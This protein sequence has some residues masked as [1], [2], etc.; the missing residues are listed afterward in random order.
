MLAHAVNKGK[1]LDTIRQHE[2]TQPPERAKA[3]EALRP[4]QLLHPIPHVQ[5]GVRITWTR[6]NGASYTGVV[7]RIHVD[8]TGT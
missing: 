2:R 1:Y 3:K 6:G 7:D 5:P 8:D 4:Q